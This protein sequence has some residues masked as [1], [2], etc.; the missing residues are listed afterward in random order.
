[1]PD[2]FDS[3]YAAIPR[4]LADA[5]LDFGYERKPEHKTRLNALHLRLTDLRRAE[6]LSEASDG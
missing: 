4:D 1:M 6:Q 2:D 5:L 3:R